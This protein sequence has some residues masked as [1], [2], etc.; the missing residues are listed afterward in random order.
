MLLGDC[1]HGIPLYYTGYVQEVKVSKIQIDPGSVVNILPIQTMNHVSLMPRSL[2]ETG[3]KIHGY[4]G[5]G[6]RALGKIKIKYQIDD[7]IAFP[8]CNVVEAQTT[9]GLLLGR[10]WTHEN[11]VIPSTLH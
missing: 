11:H 1:K 2:N 6:S 10:P 3:V 4:G 8:D 5:Q 9:Y 7:L